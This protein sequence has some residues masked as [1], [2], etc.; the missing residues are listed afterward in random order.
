MLYKVFDRH[1]TG[2]SMMGTS[3]EIQN[4]DINYKWVSEYNFPH[5]SYLM[6]NHSPLFRN[7]SRI[8]SNLKIPKI[9]AT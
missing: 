6:L 8:L 4:S 2:T 1:C 7:N 5:Y 3:R 9:I